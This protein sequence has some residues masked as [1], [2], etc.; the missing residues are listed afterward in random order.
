MQ[1]TQAMQGNRKQCEQTYHHVLC[2]YVA[3][4]HGLQ[5]ERQWHPVQALDTQV[6]C[7]LCTK[8]FNCEMEGSKAAS[9]QMHNSCC[10]AFRL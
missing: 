8:T 2:H 7:P 3:T 4:L 9:H 10:H 6:V 5:A 1:V